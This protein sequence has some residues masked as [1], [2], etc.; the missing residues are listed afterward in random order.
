[1]TWQQDA[2]SAVYKAAADEIESIDYAGRSFLG[3]SAVFTALYRAS[4]ELITAPAAEGVRCCV[5]VDQL[6][7]WREDDPAVVIKTLRELADEPEQLD[8]LH[9]AAA[10]NRIAQAR[11]QLREALGKPHSGDSLYH[12][13]DEIA[14]RVKQVERENAELKAEV[15]RLREQL[16]EDRAELR[17]STD[18]HGR[19]A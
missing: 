7:F 18:R 15:K 9:A 16:A 13:A 17:L 11:K 3:G 10:E 2:L 8:L 14:G 12:L 5:G 4:D 6:Q 1:M 19:T